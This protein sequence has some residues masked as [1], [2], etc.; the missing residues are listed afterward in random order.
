LNKAWGMYRWSLNYDSFDDV[1]PPRFDQWKHPSLETEWPRFH[2]KQIVSYVEEQADVLHRYTKAPV[3]TDMM[4]TNLLSYYEM[5][6]K[7]DVIQY[8]HYEPAKLL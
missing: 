3:G 7:L 8:N 1:D 5:N 4:V 2:C 6:K